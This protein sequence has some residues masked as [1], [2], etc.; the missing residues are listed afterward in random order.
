VKGLEGCEVTRFTGQGGG[1][2]LKGER[3]LL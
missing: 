2:F 3:E 1:F